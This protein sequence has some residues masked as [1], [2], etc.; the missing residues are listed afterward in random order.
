M[1]TCHY[2]LCEPSSSNLSQLHLSQESQYENFEPFTPCTDQSI[3][4]FLNWLLKS[5]WLYFQQLNFWIR[6]KLQRK[7]ESWKFQIL[8]FVFISAVR[9]DRMRGGRN[10]FGPMYKRD[11]ARKLQVNNIFKIN[12]FL[13]NFI[14]PPALQDM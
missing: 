4:S 13:L 9:H 6:V 7:W 10:K 14:F 1:K 5:F 12:K 11:R 2:Q 8:I 3:D